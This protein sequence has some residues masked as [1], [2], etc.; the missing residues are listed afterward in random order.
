MK[1]W[2]NFSIS[3]FG[4]ATDSFRT[5][6]IDQFHGIGIF[7]IFFRKAEW[8]LSD[9]GSAHWASSLCGYQITSLHCHLLFT[10]FIAWWLVLVMNI[11]ENNRSLDVKQP[12]INLYLIHS[13]AF[14]FSWTPNSLII[15]LVQWSALCQHPNLKTA[16]V[17]Q[18]L[19]CSSPFSGRVNPNIIKFISA[20]S[21][22]SA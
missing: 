18:W 5:G 2:R 6:R 10:W 17:V 9:R 13:L 12:S 7:Q 11:S 22:L 8:K 20:A 21:R 4:N 3:G 14:C 1:V 19:K 16:S 15:S